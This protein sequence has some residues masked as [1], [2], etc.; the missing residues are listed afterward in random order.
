MVHSHVFSIRCLVA[1]F[2]GR[3]SLSYPWPQLPD[4][5]R[6]LTNSLT[7]Q[8][9][10]HWLTHSLTEFCWVE[11]S[12]SYGWRSVDQF[13]LVSGSPLGPMAWFYPSPSI[14][15][16]CFVVLPVGRPL[17][18]EDGSVTYSAITDWSGHW[19]PIT[20]HY[21]LIWDCVPSSSPL[22]T[23][24]DYGGGI[25]TR[26]HTV[27]WLTEVEVNLRP[28][29]SRSVCLGVRRPSGTCDRF[30]FLLKFS[31]KHLRVCYFVAPSLTRGRVCNLLYNC[32]WALPEQSLSGL[33]PAE[34][35]TIF[36]CLIWESPNLEDQVPVF[37]SPRN[38]VAQL[39]PR[40]LGSLYVAF[41]DSQGL[42]W[43]YF[44]PP[45]HRDTD[46]L[47]TCPAYNISARTA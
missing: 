33:S 18:R 24:R 37:I 9:T 28:T 38:R 45:P 8:A 1:A 20:I 47:L 4:S 30:F 41:Y 36:Y 2:D 19:G 12:L 14:S 21:R 27:Y 32:F 11:L 3:R 15:D 23:R 7:H 46:Y 42:R 44:N 16:N 25:L 31:F 6:H 35:T 39:Y 17:L 10:S 26:L 22:T 5:N 29:V 40:A 13:F 34:L 43:R